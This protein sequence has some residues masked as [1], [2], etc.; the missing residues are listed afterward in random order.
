MAEKEDVIV[1]LEL[2]AVDYVTKPFNN[3]E[4]IT[5]VNTHLELKAAKEVLIGRDR[6]LGDLR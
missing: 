1:G 5:R 3:K 2:G 4:L 6:K